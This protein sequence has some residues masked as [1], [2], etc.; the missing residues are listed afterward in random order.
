MAAGE[1]T[2]MV[3]DVSRMQEPLEAVTVKVSVAE[4]A[5]E[6]DEVV[7]PVLHKYVVPPVTVKISL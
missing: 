1:T 4:G 5:V 7:A 2:R 6:I 3:N